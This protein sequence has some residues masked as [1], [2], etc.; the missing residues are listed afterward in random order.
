MANVDVSPRGEDESG[1]GTSR[2]ARRPPYEPNSA[3]N[4]ISA[5]NP[6]SAAARKAPE[7]GTFTIGIC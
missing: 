5:G 1:L 7:K 6:G 3:G 2:N 4:P